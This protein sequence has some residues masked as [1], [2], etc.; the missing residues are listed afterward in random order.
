M[1]ARLHDAGFVHKDFHPGNILVRLGRRRPP[2]A[3]DDR[4]RRPAG[5]PPAR[6]GRSAQQNL[7]LLNHYFWL[8]S[9]RTD[10]YRFLRS[11]SAPARTRPP[12]PKAFSRGIEGSTRSWAERLW[13][14]WGRRCR[15]SNKYFRKYR[16]EHAWSVASRDLD[17][18]EV[19]ALLLDPDEPVP[20]P[21]DR[22]SS[23]SRGRPPWPR[24]R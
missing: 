8:R 11:T 14:R 22:R 17:Q 7:A 5:L 2:D 15:K 1:T 24:R 10:R 23:R 16:G 20:P 12:D 21:R 4:P 6:A 19:R 9:A 3:G 18:R 13:R